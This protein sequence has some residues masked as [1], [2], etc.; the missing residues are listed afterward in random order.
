MV[1]SVSY[2]YF[3]QV[4]NFVNIAHLCDIVF[5]VVYSLF[6]KYLYIYFFT[7]QSLRP[8]TH[9]ML[10]DIIPYCLMFTVSAQY[11]KMDVPKR[12]S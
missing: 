12:G 9:R 8:M 1:Y 5:K 2:F 10:P 4:C 3:F 11:A 6:F 7:M